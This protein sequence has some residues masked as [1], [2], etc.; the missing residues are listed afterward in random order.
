MKSTLALLCLAALTAMTCTFASSQAQDFYFFGDT[1]IPV[2]ISD[3]KITVQIDTLATIFNMGSFLGNHPCLSAAAETPPEEIGR[4]CITFYLTP[5]CS[6]AAAAPDLRADPVVLRV[7]PVYITPEGA[8]FGV[9]DLVSV[10]FDETLPVDSCLTI[11][12]AYGLR[13]ED[14]SQFRHNYWWCALEDTIGE[15]PL[16]FGNDL[17]VR[18]DVEWSTATMYSETIF[19]SEPTDPYFVNQYYLKNTGQ[20]GG[21]P[22][23]DIDVAGA[24]E[25]THGGGRIAILDDGFVAHPDLPNLSPVWDIVGDTI[26]RRGWTWANG[27]GDPTPGELQNHGMAIAGIIGAAHDGAGIAG[28]APNAEIIGIKMTDNLGK[29]PRQHSA[30]A[31]AL[32]LAYAL[33]ARVISNS[34]QLVTDSSS[35]IAKAIQ[36]ISDP[37]SRAGGGGQPGVICVFSSVNQADKQIFHQELVGFP[38]KM[39]QTI[40]VGAVN[41]NSMRWAYSQY[42]SA[43][44]VV[45][46]TGLDQEESTGD[47]RGDVWTVDQVNTLG[48]NPFITGG[49]S[50]ETSDL[51]YTAKMGGTSASCAMVAGVVALL[52]E[53]RPDLRNGCAPYQ[54]VREILAGSAIDLGDPGKDPLYGNGRVNAHRAL[55]AVMRGDM[56]NSG[57]VNATDLTIL[58]NMIFF[59]APPPFD[60]RLGDVSCD[61][62]PNATDLTLMIN[63]IWYGGP[64]PQPCFRY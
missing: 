52:L 38:A 64:R 48:W 56:D 19:N 17:H 57:V 10:Q 1:M 27:D 21:T 3:E 49:L 30:H 59:A 50:G 43:L 18:D 9:T 63:H 28:I 45:A 39:P 32:Y 22:G 35:E 15:S 20:T 62:V 8:E 6:W 44:D 33:G 41:K 2:T 16:H 36:Y 53:R 26:P 60:Y 61:G 23:A 25:I 31:N 11:A 29:A 34:W 24:W 54:T 5:S 58:I 42:G 37:C 4:Y 46:P 14:S 7:L 55:L 40:A 47:F 51:D 12:S 13:F